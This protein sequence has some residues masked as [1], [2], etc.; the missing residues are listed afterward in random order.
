MEFA[1]APIFHLG[2]VVRYGHVVQDPD[3]RAPGD[4]QFWSAGLSITLRAAVGSDPEQAIT[5][6]GDGPFCFFRATH[7]RYSEALQ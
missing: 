3:A 1:V 4:A 7:S 2:P 5:H 6:T